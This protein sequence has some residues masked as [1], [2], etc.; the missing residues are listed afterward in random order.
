M[1]DLLKRTVA[2]TFA[3]VSL[4][5]SAVANT[6]VTVY[7]VKTDPNLYVDVKIPSLYTGTVY[8]GIVNLLVDGN[9]TYG[10][11]IDPYHFSATTPLSYQ[12]VDLSQAPKAPGPMTAAAADQIRRLWAADFSSSM[13]ALDAAAMQVAIWEIVT[14][15]DTTKF[16]LQHAHDLSVDTALKAR[17]SDFL[18]DSLSSGPMASLIG[19]THP[20][21][22]GQPDGQDYVIATPDLGMTAGLLGFATIGLFGFRARLSNRKG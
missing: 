19:L 20:L 10:F 3:V 16:Q 14:D 12:E 13:T 7:E 5:R 22:P 6:V 18:A 11:C 4:S 1:L 21:Q 15:G 17:V 8:A 2:V 9:P